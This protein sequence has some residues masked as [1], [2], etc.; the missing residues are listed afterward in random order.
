M[1]T[2][3]QR[4]E[5]ETI[6][7]YANLAPGQTY[8]TE[9]LDQALKDLYATQLFADVT[10]AVVA[11]PFVPKP[12]ITAFPRDDSLASDAKMSVTQSRM[13][14]VRFGLTSLGRG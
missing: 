9:T 8:T 13:I 10:I 12:E 5:P 3:N 7:A 1:V 11:C 2:G 6:R 4:L 14:S